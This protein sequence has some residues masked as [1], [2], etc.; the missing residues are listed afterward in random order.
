MAEYDKLTLH[1]HVLKRPGTYI[2]SIVPE[3]SE[4]YILK[5]GKIKSKAIEYSPGLYKIYDEIIVNALDQAVRMISEK[6]SE[7]VTE[8]HVTIDAESISVCNNGRSIDISK[9]PKYPEHCPEVI[10]ANLLTGQNFNDKA[11]KRITGGMNGLGAKLT[12]IFSKKFIVDIRNKNKRYLQVCSNNLYVIGKPEI[13]KSPGKD[14]VKITFFP[15]FPRFGV[16]GFSKDFIALMSRRVYDIPAVTK[17]LMN[18][19]KFIQVFLNGEPIKVDSFKKY[20]ELHGLT[21]TVFES[22][23]EDWEI[24]VGLSDDSFKQVSFVNGIY[25]KN[26][27]RHVDYIVNQIV[28][29]IK[30]S[31]EK[32][33]KGLSIKKSF[34]KNNI[35]V[36]IR[37]NIN[38]PSFNSQCKN[39]LNTARKDFGSV[40]ELSNK[41]IDAIGK[42]GLYEKVISF[43]QFKG[44]A[45]LAKTDG[46]KKSR[47]TVDKY[48]SA[49]YSGTKKSKDCTLILTE[50]DSAKT[51]AMS[52]LSLEQRKYY[53][54]FPLK[55]KLLNVRDVSSSKLL[56]NTEINNIKK[57][58]G[59]Q[60][61]KVYSDISSLRY[62]KIMVMT[63]Q[64]VDGSH[65]KGLVFNA[66]DVLWPSLFK[67]KNF[68]SSFLT[69]IVRVTHN[70]TKVIKSFYTLNDYNV[71][72]NRTANGLKNYYIKYYKGLGTS[73]KKEAKEYFQD[74]GKNMIYYEHSSDTEFSF[75]LAFNKKKAEERKVWLGLY[76]RTSTILP[77]NQN[78]PFDDFIHKDL[79]H[80]SF[81]DLSRSIPSVVDGL[82]VSQR[83][84]LFSAF[85]R[86]L[87]SEIKVAQFGGYVSEHSAYHHGEKSLEDTIVGM[88]RNFVGSNNINLLL[89]NG[90]FGSRLAGGKDAS[91]SRYIFT[92]LEPITK[93]IYNPLDFPLMEYLDDDGT[94]VEPL[95]YIPV[96]PMILV[97]GAR[98][99]GTGFSTNI[100]CYN[101]LDIISNIKK[102]ISGNA[103][104]DMVPWYNKFTGDIERATD[105]TFETH[106]IY[107]NDTKNIFHITE[108]PIGLWTEPYQEY[109]KGLIGK[110]V[111]DHTF[112][113]T[114]D[115]IHTTV[116]LDK[117]VKDPAKLLKM[118]TSLST[119][120]MH[121]FNADL[122]I[123][124]YTDPKDIISEFFKIRMEY[125]QK[126]K[127]YLL[128]KL[129]LDLEKLSA[130]AKFITRVND[131]KLNIK[132]DTAAVVSYLTKHKYPLVDGTFE[133]LLSMPM[134]SMTADNVAKLLAMKDQ[135]T[136]EHTNYSKKTIKELWLD[137]LAALEKEYKQFLKRSAE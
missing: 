135:K 85:K 39:E 2:G 30:M 93:H 46:K 88:A 8:I 21:E 128:N 130:K 136:M 45:A 86:N 9:H 34:I 123:V 57:I 61:D 110:E 13:T 7:R 37:C 27:G 104:S 98:G 133:Y 119:N 58:M 97:N 122:Q 33:N 54:V 28:D 118:T 125:Y 68:L 38:K 16:K 75:D 92:A 73:T 87:V 95:W 18:G 64:D 32:K 131:G 51:L 134:R 112:L 79:I 114:D 83:K 50:G 129:K 36:F 26:G 44:S 127:D 53:G 121:L 35:F 49:E 3:V 1:E 99:I 70:R 115:I 4:T 23:N 10:F 15:D 137:D 108:F 72:K 100:P 17:W 91:S 113:N 103:M 56:A 82:K 40:A 47:V 80:F 29:R 5:S 76:D 63:D 65:I 109:I 69:P 89:P 59:L 55:G 31:L 81:D 78:I 71:W 124:K 94:L 6:P 52:G 111:R 43:A 120:N 117:N 132:K 14:Y 41:F 102:M 42:M 105:T 60:Q 25:T 20:M 62:G 48:T 106:G 74:I 107:T 90:Q 22:P 96:I 84:V 126:R 24:G 66:F 116:V 77:E 67:F 12:N 101:P 11:A 19:K